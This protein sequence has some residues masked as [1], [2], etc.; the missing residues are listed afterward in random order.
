MEDNID[1]ENYV[2]VNGNVENP[3]LQLHASISSNYYQYARDAIVQFFSKP[4]ENKVVTYGW[5][6]GQMRS[7]RLYRADNGKIFVVHYSYGNL[8]DVFPFT[9]DEMM[10]YFEGYENTIPYEWLPPELI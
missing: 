8:S 5:S 1:Y 7:H 4:D 2:N 9:K 6:S 3:E 10:S